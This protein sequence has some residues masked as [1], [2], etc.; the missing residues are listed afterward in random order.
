MG[1]PENK[2][3]L[4]LSSGSKKKKWYLPI[5]PIPNSEIPITTASHTNMASPKL[6]HSS[7]LQKSQKYMASPKFIHQ[8][9]NIIFTNHPKFRNPIHCIPKIHQ[10]PNPS[11]LAP[12]GQHRIE[13]FLQQG[14]ILALQALV[15][16]LPWVAVG[17]RRWPQSFLS[18]LL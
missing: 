12:V 13:D 7:Q 16:S 15:R 18:G 11:R 2:W 6:I 1:S 3:I 5:I 14:H 8:I 9:L 4:N 10:I 17:S